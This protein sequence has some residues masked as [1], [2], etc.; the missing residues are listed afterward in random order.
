MTDTFELLVPDDFDEDMA[1]TKGWS[2]EIKVR[3]RGRVYSLICYDPVRLAQT[4]E[5]EV[6]TTGYFFEPNLIVA[7]QVDVE[8]IRAALE[9][10]ERSGQFEML[11]PDAPAYRW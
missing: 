3:S 8:H 11:N 6:R 5:D 10:L 2:Q 9:R 4:I 1:R 7:E